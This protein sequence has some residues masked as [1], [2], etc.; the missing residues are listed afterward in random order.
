MIKAND[1]SILFRSYSPFE[2]SFN[3]FIPIKN[4]KML[5]YGMYTVYDIIINE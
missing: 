5:V 2:C 3:D 1:F 4:K